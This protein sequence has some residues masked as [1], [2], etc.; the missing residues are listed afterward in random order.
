MK[1]RWGVGYRKSWRGGKG[2]KSLSSTVG[3]GQMMLK[4]EHQKKKN[5]QY[6]QVMK[7]HGGKFYN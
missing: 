2:A 1:R 7:K 6:E 4:L 5:P 3:R